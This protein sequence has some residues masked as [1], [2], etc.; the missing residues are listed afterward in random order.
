MLAYFVHIYSSANALTPTYILLLFIVSVLGA[1]WALFTLFSYHRSKSN[2][3]F[4]AFVDL[5]FVGAFIASVYELRFI[6][7][8]NCSSVSSGA[9]YAVSVGDV[10]ASVTGLSI[11]INK[12]CALLKASF[13][14]GVCLF[15]SLAPSLCPDDAPLATAVEAVLFFNE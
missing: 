2:A 4:V 10:G 7:S 9:T 12:T 15:P 11:N 5:C 8:Q 13:A 3:F 6:S 1:A 14:F